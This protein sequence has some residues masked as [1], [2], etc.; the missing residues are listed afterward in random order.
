MESEASKKHLGAFY[1]GLRDCMAVLDGQGAP[2]KPKPQADPP[3][4]P[5]PGTAEGRTVGECLLAWMEF[6]C[7]TDLNVCEKKLRTETGILMDGLGRIRLAELAPEDC[8]A[9][10]KRLLG[11]GLSPSY[12]NAIF[13]TLRAAVG[14]AI[15]T[16]AFS[17]PN[18]VTSQAGFKVPKPDN[19]GLRWLT[20]E[21]AEALLAEL[22]R[23][24]P[25]WRDM[26]L[27]SL[28]TGMRLC[29]IYRLKLCDVN[30][31][32]M[33]ANVIAKGRKRQLVRL[34]P[35]ALE[36]VK[37]RGG[38]PDELVF[39]GR[40]GERPQNP[41]R[42]AEAVKRLG[43]NEGITDSRHKVWFHTLRHTFASW[44]VQAGVDLY[45]VQALMRHKDPTMT[46]RYAHLSHDALF[47]PLEHIRAALG[48]LGPAEDP[49]I[50]TS[51]PLPPL[52][53]LLGQLFGSEGH[54][55][56]PRRPSA[57]RPPIPPKSRVNRSA[58][59]TFDSL[60]PLLKPM[61]PSTPDL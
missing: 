61:A 11:R 10:L 13:C 20:R 31:A 21:E 46:Q 14:H 29:E 35:E 50:D 43:L 53:E 23:S 48:P 8:S 51:R 55:E 44:L 54:P 24:S 15:R 12:L 37:R 30:A 52:S 56:P 3:G 17:G 33:T 16:K 32:G 19:E 36:I 38:R 7:Q 9:L 2:W 58:C 57:P 40:H 4:R 39:R 45:T 47:S 41:Y 34:T 59:V 1:Q 25:L 49:P 28:H 5:Q 27:V 60:G 22:G 6:K 26:A 42:F 18:P